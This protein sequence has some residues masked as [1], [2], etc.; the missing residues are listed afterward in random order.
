MYVMFKVYV[1]YSR[2]HDKLY[3]GFTASLSN[4][5][6]SHNK[7]GNKDWTGRYRPWLLI[8]IEEYKTKKEAMEREKEL[9]GGQGREFLRKEILSIFI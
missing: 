4:R 6:L 8:Y 3:I 2:I 7:L 9:K 1:L 5:L